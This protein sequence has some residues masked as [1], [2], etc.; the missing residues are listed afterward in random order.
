MTVVV[1]RLLAQGLDRGDAQEAK[2]TPGA[3]LRGQ[4]P[5]G[6]AYAWEGRMRWVCHNH[7]WRPDADHVVATHLRQAT[8]G[9]F[10]LG[11]DGTAGTSQL[12][13]YLYG[14]TA[15]DDTVLLALLRWTVIGPAAGPG[16]HGAEHCQGL[17]LDWEVQMRW[18][19][20]PEQ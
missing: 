7:G 11:W 5:L 14:V 1:R 10:H 12:L 3:W 13:S 17:G 18:R 15:A 6:A 9:S 16:R 8:A 19:K 20:Q 2:L 4:A